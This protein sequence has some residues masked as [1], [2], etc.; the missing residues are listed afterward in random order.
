MSP[1]PFRLRLSET[2]PTVNAVLTRRKYRFGLRW[3]AEVGKTFGLW[4]LIAFA[5]LQVLQL[6]LGFSTS[7]E[8]DLN[9]YVLRFVP[10][11]LTAIG[12]VYLMKTFPLAITTG[13]TRK[14]FFAAFAVFGAIVIAGGLAFMMSV[15]LVHNLFDADG[16]GGLDIA[17]IALLETLILMAVYFTAGAAAGAVMVR[18]NA[19]ALGSVL[20]GLLISVLLLRTIPFQLLFEEFARPGAA[21]AVGYP[22]SEELLAPFDAVLT[23]VFV[24]VVRLSL[25]RAPLPHQRI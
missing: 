13:M 10:L 4:I 7:F 11:V 9:L 12:W 24:L 8:V 6:G 17:G 25:A 22:G 19:K 2:S 1:R 16:T 3:A 20:A 21:Y 23:V 18:F 15:K 5:A 14:E